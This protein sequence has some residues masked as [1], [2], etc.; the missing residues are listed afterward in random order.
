MQAK[1]QAIIIAASVMLVTVVVVVSI[2]LYVNSRGAH[3]SMLTQYFKAVS[4][5]DADAVHKLVSKDFTSDFPALEIRPKAYELYDLGIQDDGA[6]K[7]Q[8]FVLVASTNTGKRAVV[9]EMRI[10]KTFMELRIHSL[11]ALYEGSSVKP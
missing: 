1:F 3:T 7:I 11:H 6:E 5:G 8:R 2:S 10:L 9:G 4:T